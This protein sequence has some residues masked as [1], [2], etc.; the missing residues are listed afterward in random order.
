MGKAG[1]PDFAAGW[2]DFE[3]QIK[4]VRVAPATGGD[5]AQPR[6][7]DVALD[8]FHLVDPDVRIVRTEKGI[9]LPELGG[10]GAADER[11]AEPPPEAAKPPAAA[12]ARA[13]DPRAA[14]EAAHRGRARAASRTAA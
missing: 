8:L 2:K 13:A 9:A 7:I 4:E 11:E 14:R 10:G 12:G 1:D 6:A 3:L 5:P